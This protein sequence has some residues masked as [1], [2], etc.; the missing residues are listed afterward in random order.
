MLELCTCIHFAHFYTATPNPV[1]TDE[2][3][4]PSPKPRD[5]DPPDVILSFNVNVAP[6][7]Y[8]TC[9]VGNT[10]VDVAVLSREVTVGEYIPPSAESLVKNIPMTNVTVTNVAVTLRTREPGNYQCNISVFRASGS[11]LTNATTSPI[12]I[13]GRMAEFQVGWRSVNISGI[14]LLY[15]ASNSDR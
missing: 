9:Q 11:N 8:V 10:P 3:F 14:K 15:G 1:V 5:T 12:R 6:P 2:S 7:T 13:S 4:I